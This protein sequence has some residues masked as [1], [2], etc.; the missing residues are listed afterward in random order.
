VK[1]ANTAA[2]GALYDEAG[3]L[4]YRPSTQAQQLYVFGHDRVGWVDWLGALAFVGVLAAISAHGG[5]RFYASLRGPRHKAPARRVYMY[6]V[7]ERFWHWLQT[8]AIVLLLLT[9]LV[10]H[11][12]DVFGLFSFPHVV[13]VHN[14]LAAILVINAALSLFYHL[15]SGEIRQFLPRPYGFFDQAIVQARFYLQGIFRGD[16]HPF[17]KTPQ[18]KMNPL[19]QLTY[20]GILNVLLPLQVITGALMWGVQ[21]W[22]QAANWFGG[23]PFLAPFHSLIA[24][25]FAAFIAAHVYLTT[26]GHE[27]TAGVKAMMLGWEEVED[28]A[29]M[30][31]ELPHDHTHASK[32]GGKHAAPESEGVAV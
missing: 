2:N 10:I 28:P 30:I 13:I 11:R 7:Y 24:W 21:R 27:P 4:Y 15:A 12:P 9:G 1:D 5:L 25:L 8:F 22:P 29:V 17:E 6:A 19:Q 14:V 18:K 20:F 23:L 3:A 16:P 31:E 32:D 26:T